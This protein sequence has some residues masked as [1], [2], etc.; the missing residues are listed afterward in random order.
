MII[1]AGK[2]F[3]EKGKR[4]DFLA[5]SREAMIQ[6]RATP[7]CRDFVV[8]ADPLDEARVN[9]F[10]EWETE[11][12]LIQFRGNGPDDALT[13]LIVDASVTQREVK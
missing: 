10:E 1:V 11:A 4:Q 3:I 12:A 6:A 2:L 9:I 5:S 8:S 13:S 7:G